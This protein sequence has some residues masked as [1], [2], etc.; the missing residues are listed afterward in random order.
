MGG[1]APRSVGPA[2]AGQQSGL[3]IPLPTCRRDGADRRSPAGVNSGFLS[4]RPQL[5]V[6]IPQISGWHPTPEFNT[7]LGRGVKLPDLVLYALGSGDYDIVLPQTPG[8]FIVQAGCQNE[9]DKMM[10]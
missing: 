3:N 2:A 1:T 10:A 9:S 7:A 5:P 6:P 8:F 4:P